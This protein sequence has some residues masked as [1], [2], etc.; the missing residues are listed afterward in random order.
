M[1][2]VFILPG[3]Q[4]PLWSCATVTVSL[5]P[6][7]GERTESKPESCNQRKTQIEDLLGWDYPNR[8]W[9]LK[10]EEWCCP[11]EQERCS[12]TGKQVKFCSV[13]LLFLRNRTTNVKYLLFLSSSAN[14]WWKNEIKTLTLLFW[15]N[16]IFNSSAK[17]V[18]SQ[19]QSTVKTRSLRF[20]LQ[21]SSMQMK[22]VS[23]TVATH[24]GWWN[25]P[26]AMITHW[27]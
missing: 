13:V 1:Q 25:M 3:Q 19:S 9:V 21:M 16:Y 10:E 15:R 7:R 5:L 18:L 20:V 23:S 12:F 24:W 14:K 4:G 8:T 17:H 2:N 27:L 6:H 26:E 11:G 22:A